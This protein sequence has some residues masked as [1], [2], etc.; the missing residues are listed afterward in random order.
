MVNSETINNLIDNFQKD[1]LERQHA[2]AAIVNKLEA[3][4][5]ALSKTS[6]PTSKEILIKS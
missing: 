6:E 5:N 3:K 1:T 2:I 4:V